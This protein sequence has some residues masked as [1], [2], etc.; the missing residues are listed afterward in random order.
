MSEIKA[1]L[2][3]HAQRIKSLTEMQSH[4]EKDAIFRTFRNQQNS[5]MP[6]PRKSTKGSKEAPHGLHYS[7]QASLMNPQ[8]PVC[9]QRGGGKQ[10]LP[11]LH[12]KQLSARVTPCL[13]F[14][15]CHHLSPC[16]FISKTHLTQLGDKSGLRSTP[17]AAAAAHL[18]EST[19]QRFRG[20]SMQHRPPAPAAPTHQDTSTTTPPQER[21]AAPIPSVRS[22]SGRP[23]HCATSGGCCGAGSPA[24]QLVLSWKFSGSALAE[25]QSTQ[26]PVWL[27]SVCMALSM[28]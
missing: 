25:Q 28:T 7:A 12:H 8:T 1:S 13:S 19:Y 14:V 4:A 3:P 21:Q 24:E 16:N 2:E 9:V 18:H 23:H 22:R 6:A 10:K 20:I 15:F 11:L 5:T 26:A 17:P 27:P